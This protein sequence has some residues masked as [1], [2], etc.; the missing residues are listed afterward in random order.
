MQK[1]SKLVK[2]NKIAPRRAEACDGGLRKLDIKKSSDKTAP[3]ANK[4]KFL[5]GERILKLR[6]NR[7]PN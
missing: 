2:A 6:E 1:G 3:S 5:R 4:E 7:S